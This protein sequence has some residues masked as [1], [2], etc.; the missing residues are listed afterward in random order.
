MRSYAWKPLG[1]T[2]AQPHPGSKSV[3]GKIAFGALLL[4]LIC[5][6]SSCLLGLAGP[7]EAETIRVGLH[8]GGHAP[9]A[10]SLAG[11]GLWEAERGR[12]R[13]DGE[14][15]VT[16]LAA[17]L[18]VRFPGA[19][20]LAVGRWIAF[21]PDRD[22]PPLALDAAAYRGGLR[23]DLQSP[24]RL[25]VVNTLDLEDYLP[26][27]VPNEIFAV[28]G[29]LEAQAI[30]S[31]TLALYI[32]DHQRRHPASDGFD[33]CAEGHCQ[34][35]R[36]AGS[37]TP[38]ATQAV[39]RTRGQILTSRGRPI[40]AAYH[41]N[42][43]GH[44][45]ETDEAW[46]GSLR[47]DY[48]APVPSPYDFVA[49]D[50]GYPDCYR[51]QVTAAPRELRDRLL[52][53]AGVDVGE[54]REARVTESWPSGRAKQLR[55]TGARAGAALSRPRDIRAVLGMRGDQTGKPYDYDLRSVTVERKGGRFLI[56]GYG[57]GDGVGL[58][59]HGA[60]GMA[61]AGLTYE[62]ILGYYYRE[63]ALTEDCGRGP[64]R[65][66]PRPALDAVSSPAARLARR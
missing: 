40:L 56:T 34:V 50:L 5:A 12:G 3:L 52:R 55:I 6:V 66:L 13:L 38:L 21:S 9:R 11:R 23:V 7:A 8:F 2:L 4:A 60:I 1:T 30:A 24:G 32:R 17:G 25:R 18:E 47:L 35:Y 22:A 51:W 33:V 48:L 14:A 59:Q 10:L 37:E 43:G 36:G 49:G 31:R 16:A 20:P 65:S 61:R 29:A 46:P 44:T 41:A 62:E 54:V 53:V 39:Q 15:R 19:P 28:P 63:V 42:S 57:A 27:V 64:S 45:A 58:S 26:G